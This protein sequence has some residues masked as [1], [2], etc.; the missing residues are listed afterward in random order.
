MSGTPKIS[1]AELMEMVRQHLEEQRHRKAVEEAR[2]RK[3]AEERERKK[4]LGELKNGMLIDVKKFLAEIKKQSKEFNNDDFEMFCTK[5]SSFEKKIHDAQNVKILNSLRLMFPKIQKEIREFIEKNF[6]AEERNGIPVEIDRLHYQLSH[7]EK[8][9]SDEENRLGKN[10]DNRGFK[11][12]NEEIQE[13]MTFLL[14]GDT[15]DAGSLLQKTE[16]DFQ[17]RIDRVTSLD[18]GLKQRKYASEEV[19]DELKS[20]IEGLKTDPMIMLWQPQIIADLESRLSEAWSAVSLEQFEVPQVILGEVTQLISDIIKNVNTCQIKADQRKYIANGIAHTLCE[21]GFTVAS[22]VEEH[23]GH[24]ATALIIHADNP[25]G[26]AVDVS[27]PIDSQVWYSVDGYPKTSEAI[28]GGGTAA[29]CDEAENVLNE[30][31][32]NLESEFGIKMSNLFWE[33]KD[34]NRTLRRKDELPT[35]KSSRESHYS[36]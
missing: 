33:G 3:E 5:I 30:M 7:L 24:P 36:N 10:S 35:G 22:P 20:M 4:R 16:A 31:H 27:V 11:K 13:I 21:M 26:K 25:L 34:P 29:V 23:P 19:C 32:R 8:R 6:H 14:S 18:E 28:V 12:T 15:K 9:M 2:L 17:T 1:E